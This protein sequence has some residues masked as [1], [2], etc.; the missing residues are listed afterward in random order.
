[1]AIDTWRHSNSSSK[2]FD[3]DSLAALS[4]VLVDTF[5]L[6]VGEVAEDTT[7]LTTTSLFPK[8]YLVFSTDVAGMGRLIVLLVPS[9]GISG[10]IT[11]E[12]GEYVL[13]RVISGPAA[14]SIEFGEYK[15]I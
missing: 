1:M 5:A 7:A 4:H 11:M 6:L 2:S 15:P 8:T 13:R 12:L 9:R 14:D 10:P 3:D